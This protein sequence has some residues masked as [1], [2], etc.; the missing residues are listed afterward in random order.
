MA[1]AILFLAV[2]FLLYMFNLSAYQ[3]CHTILGSIGRV[4]D[5]SE[6]AHCNNVQLTHTGSI[7][8]MGL[9]GILLLVDLVRRKPR[10]P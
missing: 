4:F 2:G 9:G 8:L 6:A 1:L 5:Q 7:G 3:E 10:S